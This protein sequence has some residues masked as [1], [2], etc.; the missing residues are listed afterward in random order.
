MRQAR[1][2]D[3]ADVAKIMR[4]ALKAR[5]PEIKFRVRIQ[6]YAG[7]SSINVYYPESAGLDADAVKEI[8]AFVSGY[9][10]KGFDGMIDMAFYK[11]HWLLPDGSVAPARSPGTAGS[12]GYYERYDHPAPCP[13]AELVQLGGG[14]AS[15][16]RERNA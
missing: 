8:N 15:L 12:M 7:G 13:E 5:W 6:R 14:Y 11:E 2:I 4:R 1:Y 9:S 16:Y 10:G 3:T